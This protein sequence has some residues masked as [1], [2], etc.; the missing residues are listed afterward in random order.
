MCQAGDP[1][2][3]RMLWDATSGSI[4]ALI[5]RYIGDD[6]I[7]KDV[8]QEAFISIFSNISNFRWKGDGSLM[9][10]CRRIAVNKA[11]NYLRDNKLRQ[12]STRP[13]DDMDADVEE[14]DADDVNRIPSDVLLR[15]IESLPDGYRT[16][17]NLFC[18]ENFSHKQIAKLLG[19]NEKSSSS[20][21]ARAKALLAKRIKEYQNG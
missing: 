13:I 3:Q 8:L 1:Q 10:W 19:I 4:F 16:V 18:F 21:L 5:S 7:A 14:P 17:L 9:P 12:Q 20:Q 15:M 6:D 11:I 2:G